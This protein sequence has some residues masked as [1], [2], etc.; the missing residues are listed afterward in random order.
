MRE[1]EGNIVRKIE[2]V[3]GRGVEGMDVVT[4]FVFI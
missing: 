1:G 4:D 3:K 2:V